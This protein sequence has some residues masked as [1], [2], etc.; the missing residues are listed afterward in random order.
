M[1]SPLLI[2][3]PLSAFNA[4]ANSTLNT[5]EHIHVMHCLFK[6][7]QATAIFGGF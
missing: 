4:Q 3:H 2:H 5:A 7:L 1:V 6:R